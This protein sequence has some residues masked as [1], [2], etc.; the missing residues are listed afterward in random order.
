MLKLGMKPVPGVNRVTVKK[1]KN[2][3][4]VIQKP[5]V[6]KGGSDTY[7]IFGEAKIEDLSSA[8]S[9]AA[10]D[11]FRSAAPLSGLR[12]N[13][14]VAASSA[15]P[16]AAV[17]GGDE[18]D[19]D[20]TGIEEKDIELVVSQAGVSRGKAIA[21]LKQNDSDIVAAIMQLTL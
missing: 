6:F 2:I 3:L 1:S 11:Q 16:A 13:S 21:A 12:Q 14:G 10:A 4:F 8:A 5:E 20:A 17:P 15:A 7:V 18:E 19:L 9:S